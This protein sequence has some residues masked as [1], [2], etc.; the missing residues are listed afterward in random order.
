MQ[1]SLQSLDLKQLQGTFGKV[2]LEVTNLVN[3]QGA[4]EKRD[5]TN[6][7]KDLSAQKGEL[8]LRFPMAAGHVTFAS[9]LQLES[10]VADLQL[11]HR[12]RERRRLRAGPPDRRFRCPH[13]GHADPC[14]EGT[15]WQAR[16]RHAVHRWR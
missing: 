8:Q 3:L 10:L 4:I 6:Y 9:P 16:H 7:I 11:R 5:D 2:W 14:A 12:Q 15:R 1:L 13:H